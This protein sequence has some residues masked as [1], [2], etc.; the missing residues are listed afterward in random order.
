MS[1]ITDTKQMIETAMNSGDKDLMKMAIL[2][3]SKI[4]DN[5]PEP[6]Q[7]PTQEPYYTCD[8]CG[9]RFPFDKKRK[10]CPSC[11]KH[12]L[13][14]VDVAK[15]PEPVIDTRSKRLRAT[16]VENFTMTRDPNFDREVR[17]EEGNVI[18]TKTLSQSIQVTGNQFQDNNDD[19]SADRDFTKQVKFNVS[20]RRGKVNMVNW[21]CESCNKQ[22]QKHPAF[23]K[24]LYC[25]KCLIKG[26]GRGRNKRV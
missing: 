22:E 13:V 1:I 11:K 3:Q 24:E 2:M 16:D 26:K 8:A 23:S 9:E 7:E 18:G 10:R 14:L 15:E 12:K 5:L 19:C 20:Q 21:Q 25:D 17:D 6:T 4:V